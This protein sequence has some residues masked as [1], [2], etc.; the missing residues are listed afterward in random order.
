MSISIKLISIKYIPA[1]RYRKQHRY[2]GKY[3]IVQYIHVSI[4]LELNNTL[5]KFDFNLI[6]MS[7]ITVTISW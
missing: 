3:L 6:Q 7:A 1:I 5:A 2:L 4:F